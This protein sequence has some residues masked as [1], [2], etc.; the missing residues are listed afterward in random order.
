MGLVLSVLSKMCVLVMPARP[1]IALTLHER[2]PP[3]LRL[4]LQ[5]LQEVLSKVWAAHR[6]SSIGLWRLSPKDQK[7]L[8]C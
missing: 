7:H 4:Q 1:Q 5:E 3:E 8:A 6:R 2:M